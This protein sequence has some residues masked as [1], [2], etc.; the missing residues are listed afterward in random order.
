[1]SMGKNTKKRILD[2]A[3]V[4]FCRDGIEAISLRKIICKARV[5]SAAIH[6]H[7]GSKE[8][9]VKAVCSRRIGP[10]NRER[11]VLLDEVEERAGD[12][13]LRLED[14]LYAVFA[15]AVR[16]AASK[17]GGGFRILGA[18]ISTERPR[19]LHM[20][21]KMQFGEVEQ[22]FDAAYKR[23]LP[24]LPERDRQWRKH[25][26]LGAFTHALNQ[27]EWI[28]IASGGQADLLDVEVAIE[29][30]I[31]FMAAGMK[32]PLPEGLH[33]KAALAL[34]EVGADR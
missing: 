14:V 32:A 22:R 26:A 16:L 25:L 34:T 4:L 29:Q 6:Y 28:R 17:S 5:N 7:F 20:I 33:D 12:G 13:P 15:P 18:R 8:E 10:L 9:L 31:N 30:I 1:M 3:E 11:L 23:A 2:A 24:N 27:Q 19:Y 21:F